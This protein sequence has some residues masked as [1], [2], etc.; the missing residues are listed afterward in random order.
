MTASRELSDK[1][2]ALANV[3]PISSLLFW[4]GQ[5]CD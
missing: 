2:L 1:N 4:K 5:Q 3:V